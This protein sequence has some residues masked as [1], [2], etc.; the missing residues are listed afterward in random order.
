MSFLYRILYAAHAQGTHHKI[1]LKALKE[2][3][4]KD[5]D[6]WRRVFL[7]HAARFL[8][9]SKAPDKEFKDF[10]NHVLHVDDGDWGGAREAATKWYDTLVAKLKRRN[11]DGAAYAAGVLSHYYSDPLMPLHTGS[12]EAETTIHR[13][14][15]WGVSK[16][17]EELW[18]TAPVVDVPVPSG[19]DWL[20]KML[21]EGAVAARGA[22]WPLIAHFDLDR[23]AANPIE[24]LD[25]EGRSLIAP[26]LAHAVTGCSRIFDRAFMEAGVEPPSVALTAETAVAGLQIPVRWVANRLEDAGER[27]LVM[28]MHAELKAHG[29]LDAT[30]TEDVRVVRDAATRR[31]AKAPREAAAAAAGG[32]R[33]AGFAITRDADVARL[34]S[35]GPKT[36]ARLAAVGV[37]TVGDLISANTARVV[38][39]LNQRWID[40]AEVEKW[41]DQARLLLSLPR[42]R[43]GH[44]VMLVA[45]GY[46]DL[47][48]IAGADPSQLRA[49]LSTTAKIAWVRR[50][51]RDPQAP[52]LGDVVE[53]IGKARGA[54][55]AA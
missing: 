33:R 37:V 16:S 53:W 13:A 50:E 4:S 42:L 5:A 47:T 26:L 10:T 1:A 36:A 18:D 44:A 6:R 8:E 55:A 48:Q 24:G 32:R 49:E 15:E 30:L 23:A 12:S 52:D 22:Y 21:R 9:G 43:G 28:A 41:R 35:I 20:G 54:L 7:K 17:F 25:A 27:A 29:R 3:R 14:L 31:Q 51:L 46:R 19:A 2:L 39:R 11:W 38:R 45:A 40:K 34:P